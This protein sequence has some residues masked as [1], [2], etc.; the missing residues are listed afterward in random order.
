MFWLARHRARRYLR[1]SLFLA[2]TASI[3]L[4]LAV[5]PAVRWIDDRTRWTLLGFGAAG[6]SAVVS[7]LS[8]SLL[9]LI[10][11]AFSI[12]LLAIQI[13][14]GQLSPRIIATIFR[15]PFLK[16]AISVFVFSYAYSLAALSRIG[17][18]V[19]QLP[20]TLAIAASLSSLALFIY[21]VQR[22]GEAFRPGTLMTYV[23]AETRKVIGAMYPRP[24]APGGDHAVLA[25]DTSRP[26]RVVVQAQSAH[27]V[28]AFDAEGLRAIATRCGCVVELV[29]QVGDFVPAGDPLFR[30]YGAGA[31]AAREAELRSRVAFGVERT[32]EQDPEFGFRIIV[33]I[34]SKA[35]SPAINDPTTGVLAVDQLHHLLHLVAGRQL[36]TGVVRDEAGEVR[37]VYRTPDWEDFVALAAT[38]V[39]VYGATN[40]QV[41]RRLR[42]MYDHLLRVVPEERAEAL[43]R[44]VALLE[45]TLEAAWPRPAD[46]AIAGAADLQGF[47]GRRPPIAGPDV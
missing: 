30:L 9:A 17:D 38:E 47:G 26:D 36:D 6:A 29:P 15:T 12:L 41:T 14:G 22:V 8:S 3:L 25:L 42:A 31:P 5:A 39:R 34:A 24:F 23:A 19:P 11:F 33:D 16:A 18:R 27:V 13:A 10:V 44:E 40:P 43:R 37:L 4:A 2:P 20:V 32:M 21:L 35:L 28:L 46:R 45:G 7:G 1:G